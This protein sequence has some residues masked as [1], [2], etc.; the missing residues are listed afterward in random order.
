MERC[1]Q[2]DFENRKVFR[3]RFSA[4][5]ARSQNRLGLNPTQLAVLMQLC[6]FWWE[7]DRRPYPSKGV[8]A[9]RLSL[10]S[11]QVQRHIAALE[12]AGLVKRVERRAYH[13]GK[14]TNIY[15]LGG[16]V[17]RLKKLEPGFLEVDKAARTARRAVSKRGYRRIR[18][19]GTAKPS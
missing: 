15:D 7:H 11:R 18:T 14:Q 4:I 3:I 1:D 16:L 8:L 2:C 9:E 6:D 17:A 10:S 5:A 13:G 19:G 12:T